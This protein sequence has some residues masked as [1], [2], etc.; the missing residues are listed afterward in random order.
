MHASLKAA[1]LAGLASAAPSEEVMV[2]SIAYVAEAQAIL[3]QP[4]HVALQGWLHILCLF[5]STCSAHGRSGA[6]LPPNTTFCC[7]HRGNW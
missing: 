6:V 1:G 7:N 4:A 2:G 5:P 3:E